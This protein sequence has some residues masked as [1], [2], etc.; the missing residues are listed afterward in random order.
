MTSPSE[1]QIATPAPEERKAVAWMFTNEEGDAEFG[2]NYIAL[3]DR[4]YEGGPIVPLYAAPADLQKE[5]EE[6]RLR[7]AN[8]EVSVSFVA[9]LCHGKSSD[10]A[11]YTIRVRN[12]W[13]AC[14]E[15]LDAA[16]AAGKGGE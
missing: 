7:M 15:S 11:S 3:K 1:R 4:T 10:P 8:L 2:N 16:L 14:G 6:L 5:N 12:D 13:K 9:A